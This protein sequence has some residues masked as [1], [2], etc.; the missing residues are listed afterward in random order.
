MKEL[1]LYDRNAKMLDAL[2]ESLQL[3]ISLNQPLSVD[4]METFVKVF[5]G[6]RDANL[7]E[8]GKEAA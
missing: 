6:M 8:L 4:N 2:L 7:K 5:K 1:P 3:H